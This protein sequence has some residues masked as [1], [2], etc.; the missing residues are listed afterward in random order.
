MIDSK[1]VQLAREEI[2][3]PS[4]LLSSFLSLTK[5][6]AVL[7]AILSL[8]VFFIVPIAKLIGLSAQS[9]TGFSLE[10]YA[11]I[12]RQERLWKTLK[13]TFII[14]AGSSSVS[15]LLGVLAAWVMAYTD[16]RHKKALHMA[17]MLSF[18]LPSYVLTLSWSS[19]MGTQGIAAHVLQWFNPNAKPWSM[20]SYGGIIFVMGIHHFPLV[21]LL[22]VDVLKKIPRDLEWATRAGGAGKLKTFC[23]I[24]LPLALPGLT[25]G[26][27]LVFLS[28]LDN[29]GIP[30]FLGIP[31]NI[32]VLST[33]IYEEIVGFGPSAFARGAVL[34]V[35][36]GM[37]AVIVTLLQW[38]AVRKIKTADTVMID[39]HPRYSLGKHRT[40]IT[41][42]VWAFLAMIT[43]VPL[44]SMVATS[45]KK[46]YG[47]PFHPANLTLSNYRYILF[48]NP[49]VWQSIQNSLMLS[50][51]TLAVCL[52]LGS[53]LAYA[54]V[55]KPS[56][57][58]K[59]AELAVAVPYTLPGIVFGLAMIFAWME[60]IPGWN[61]GIYGSIR[62]LFIAYVC[63]FLILQV[64]AGIAS[65]MQIDVSMEEAARI[66]GAGFWKKWTSILLPLLLPGLL[67]GAFLVFLTAFTEL[68]V[69]ALLWSTGSQTIGVTIFSFEQAG[70]TLYSTA[71][72]SLIVIMII[73][74]MAVLHTLN[75]RQSKKGVQQP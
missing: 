43:V 24:T 75:K 51:T 9:S 30:A 45:L 18:I 53:L 7:L 13:D 40:W 69:S 61:P 63:R 23:L 42:A 67:S 6:A 74:G 47:L 20:Y 10:H 16:L 19:F 71:L 41:A 27:L 44:V 1:N 3:E 4:P 66:F 49:K 60:P 39:N 52:V 59:S 8:L 21:Y 48:E 68:T 56:W 11:D 17:M 54:R 55:R 62:I 34:S 35:M 36:L 25:A 46:A 38:L 50:V 15:M 33:L 73:V 72:S 5:R 32:S 58:T 26:G 70:D 65:F 28:S 14:V 29:F 57:I 31:K 2:G 64:R 22:T 12:L 37:I